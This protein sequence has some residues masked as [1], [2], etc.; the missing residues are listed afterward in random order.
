MPAGFDTIA[1]GMYHR[2]PQAENQWFFYWNEYHRY[3]FIPAAVALISSLFDSASM[4]KICVPLL[5]LTLPEFLLKLYLQ[6][7]FC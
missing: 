6:L 5:R 1:K 7:L 3:P 4:G 2:H